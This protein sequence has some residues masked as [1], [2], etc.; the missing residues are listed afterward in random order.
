M[1]ECCLVPY[2]S[3][4][5][6]SLG[7]LPKAGTTHSE[8]GPPTSITEQE[9]APHICLQVSLMEAISQLFILSRVL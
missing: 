5:L 1:E 3:F 6:L 8:L 7:H 4:N 2:G 9:N